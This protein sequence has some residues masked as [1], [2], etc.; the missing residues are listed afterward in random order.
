PGPAGFQG[1]QGPQGPQ[2]AQAA[3]GTGV[4]TSTPSGLPAHA[5]PQFAVGTQDVGGGGTVRATGTIT[6]S[7]S[8]ERLKGNVNIIS[9]AD[10]KLYTLN[11]YFYRQNKFAEQFGYQDYSR[12]VGL[13]AQEVEKVLPEVVRIAPVD[14]GGQDENGIP[15]S[16]T[17]ENYLTLHYDR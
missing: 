1:A 8:D 11:G 12:E 3:Q 2:G 5:Q 10:K 7:L 14:M 4:S 15:Q 9:D 6:Q 13:I 17:G 16:R